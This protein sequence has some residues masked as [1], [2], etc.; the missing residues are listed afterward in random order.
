MCSYLQ[1]SKIYAP[2]LGGVIH[3]GSAVTPKNIIKTPAFKYKV[4]TLFAH[5]G[6]DTGISWQEMKRQFDELRNKDSNYPT[7][8]YLY[9][10]GVHGTPIRMI[11]WR[12]VLSYI[13][14]IQC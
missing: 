7:K 5:G 9:H 11:D 10:G 3:V 1:E 8:F 13:L 14:S 4:P 12:E 2:M 6:Y